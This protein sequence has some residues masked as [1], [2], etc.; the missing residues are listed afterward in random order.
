MNI[1][2]ATIAL[3]LVISSIFQTI[4]IV[5]L[6][7]KYPGVKHFG[8][9]CSFLAL[10]FLFVML[11]ANNSNALITVVAGNSLLL[12]AVIFQYMGLVR[13]LNLPENKWFP[14]LVFGFSLSTLIYF[15]FVFDSIS[16]RIFFIYLSFGFMALLIAQTLY[17]QRHA[18]LPRQSPLL[19]FYF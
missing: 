10:G 14:P 6:S 7:S 17:H 8:V 1:D 11:Q 2:L 16:Y 4:F 3:I 15:L 13:F 12:L 5:L 19:F 18:P 9:S